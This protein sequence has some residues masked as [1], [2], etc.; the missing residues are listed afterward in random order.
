V[1]GQDEAVAENTSLDQA[2]K[3]PDSTPDGPGTTA[4]AAA[5]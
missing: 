3:A 4:E 2:G 5:A 1:K